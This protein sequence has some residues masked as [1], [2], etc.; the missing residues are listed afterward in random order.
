[1][2]GGSCS[3]VNNE[4]LQYIKWMREEREREAAL[5][6]SLAAAG[7]AVSNTQDMQLDECDHLSLDDQ[8]EQGDLDPFENDTFDNDPQEGFDDTLIH[9]QPVVLIDDQVHTADDYA[10]LPNGAIINTKIYDIQSPLLDANFDQECFGVLQHAFCPGFV[11]DLP[12]LTQA[13][14]QQSNFEIC[15]VTSLR[16]KAQHSMHQQFKESYDVV[17]S[18]VSYHGTEQAETIARTG[19]RGAASKRAKFG[20]GVYSSKD[21]YHALA[22]SKLTAD[23]KMTFL[24]VDLH[25]GPVALGREDQVFP[26]TLLFPPTVRFPHTIHSQVLSRLPSLVSASQVDFGQNMHGQQVLTL[27]NAEGDIYC[28]SNGKS[29]HQSSHPSYTSHTT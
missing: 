14:G 2:S 16:N 15:E 6:Q 9:V 21:V 4:T 8:D 10:K 3:R 29:P 23:D 25:L 5:A 28:S 1:M 20:R 17:Q 13:I 11:G 19:F 27:T 22:Y 26:S 7:P 12:Q 24:V 18:V